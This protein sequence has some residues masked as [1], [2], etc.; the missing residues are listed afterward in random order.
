MIADLR[1]E[2]PRLV[3]ARSLLAYQFQAA[4]FANSLL[5]ASV[6]LREPS[7]GLQRLRLLIRCV[8]C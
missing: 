1:H 7:I 3:R 5:P 4:S 2:H 6:A 8:L